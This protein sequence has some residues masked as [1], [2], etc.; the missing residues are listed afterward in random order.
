MGS[1]TPVPAKTAVGSLRQLK[2]PEK[3][4]WSLS[5]KPKIRSRLGMPERWEIGDDTSSSAGEDSSDGGNSPPS[6]SRPIARLEAPRI[7][8][9]CM[10]HSS[11]KSEASVAPEISYNPTQAMASSSKA[12]SPNYT[13]KPERSATAPVPSS[14]KVPRAAQSHS[15]AFPPLDPTFKALE[16][17][18][19]LRNKTSCANCGTVGWDFPKNRNGQALCTRECRMA[20]KA[21]E[22]G[23]APPSVK[24]KEPIRF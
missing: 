23:V 2:S 10:T 13:V 8:S 18:S 9:I 17:S 3:R 21:R 19:K 7:P 6:S 14:S 12:R 20:F 15:G 16:K 11:F 24:G 22:V 1:F 4:G 5:V